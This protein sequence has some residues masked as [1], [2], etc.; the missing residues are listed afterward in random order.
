MFVFWFS[1]FFALMVIVSSNYAISRSAAHLLT[2]WADISESFAWRKENG[3]FTTF[4]LTDYH[5]FSKQ[6]GA[7]I[8][9]DE[10]WSLSLSDW[11]SLEYFPREH[12]ANPPALDGRS[13]NGAAVAGR[14]AACAA[15]C[16]QNTKTRFVTRI[17]FGSKQPK[18]PNDKTCGNQHN[19]LDDKMIFCLKSCNAVY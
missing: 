14:T 15:A 13:D 18:E 5:K 3:P 6:E 7:G 19:I 8:E 2:L 12:S 4:L 10:S 16:I 9:P 1:H 11:L 17:R